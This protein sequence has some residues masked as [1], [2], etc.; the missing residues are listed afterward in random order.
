MKF[1]ENPSMGVVIFPADIHTDIYI[2]T[3]IYIY[4]Y[5]SHTHLY[6]IHTD[7]YI[8][9]YIYIT[10]TLIHNT[11]IHIHTYIH[12][13]IYTYIYT[14]TLIHNTYIQTYTNIYTYIHITHT[15]IHNTYIQTYTY[16]YTYIHKIRLKTIEL[17]QAAWQI[18]F[19]WVK[20]HA[21]TQGNEM[22]DTLAK[23][24]AADLD[25]AVSYNKIPKSV[26]KRELESTS[27]D[28]WQRDWNQTTKG[29]TTKDY[30]PKVTERL[31]RKL[32]INRSLTTTM[33]GHGNIKAY[34]H[35]LFFVFS[36]PLCCYHKYLL[37]LSNTTIFL[38]TCRPYKLQ[39]VLKTPC[40]L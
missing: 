8:H 13:Y 35:R 34:L 4:T 7:I 3:Y 39:G 20:A 29:S 5:I 40:S 9:I 25:I 24:A 28:K 31:N 15:L 21:L 22:A 27:V 38:L 1:H 18:K 12:T 26:V 17:E 6:I 2:H 11:Y 30:F 10:H 37:R 16:I 19:C 36:I 32:S 23:E 14:H 33:T